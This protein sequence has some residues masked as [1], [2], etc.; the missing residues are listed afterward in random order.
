VRVREARYEARAAEGVG[1]L[2]KHSLGIAV[3]LPGTKLA[4]LARKQAGMAAWEHLFF[5]ALFAS[6]PDSDM[7]TILKVSLS[8]S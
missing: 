2:T 4:T 1:L 6:L 5:A 3:I 7:A 8:V